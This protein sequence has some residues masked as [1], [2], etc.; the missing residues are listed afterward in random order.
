M[1]PVILVLLCAAALVLAGCD[2]K[3]RA[4]RK[5]QVVRLL[6][7]TPPPPPPPPRQEDRP[8]PRP[9][10]KPQP[11]DAPKPVDAPAQQAALK[12]DEAAGNGPGNGLTAGA[13]NK[14]YTD[15]KLGQGNTIGGAPAQD[16]LTQLAATAYANAATRALNEF[17]VRDKSVKRHEY[18]VRVEL[19]LTDSGGLRRAELLSSTGDEQTDQAL[20]EALGRF[21]GTGSPPPAKLPQPMRLQIS[22]RM[23][24]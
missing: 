13:V 21:P 5:Q 9:D 16:A 24:G 18:R 11:R 1:K 3:P 20:R 4:K 10:D 15:Q 17:L 2:E 12:S 6:P 14:D 19:W 23:M 22:N 7:D 8:P